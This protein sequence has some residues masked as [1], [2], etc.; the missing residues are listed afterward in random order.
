MPDDDPEDRNK[1]RLLTCA[2]A[3]L[4]HIRAVRWGVGSASYVV[5]DRGVKLMITIEVRSLSE[6]T[7]A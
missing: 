4:D 3:C 7:E 5:P 2:A 6:A 1:A